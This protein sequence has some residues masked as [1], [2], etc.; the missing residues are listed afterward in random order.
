M[1]FTTDLMRNLQ[2]I[3]KKY[4]KRYVAHS[5]LNL[6]NTLAKIAISNVNYTG[7]RFTM[8]FF[9]LAADFCISTSYRSLLLNIL[10]FL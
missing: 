1:D 4:N 3:G 5:K 9:V 10:P 7:G 2:K 8:L 6:L